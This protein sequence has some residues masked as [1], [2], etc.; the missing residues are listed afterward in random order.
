MLPV[1]LCEYNAKDEDPSSDKRS[2]PVDKTANNAAHA[3]PGKY[4]MHTVKPANSHI[5]THTGAANRFPHATGN[6]H[7]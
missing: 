6:T 5:H 3:S 7:N 1:K 4:S 2:N